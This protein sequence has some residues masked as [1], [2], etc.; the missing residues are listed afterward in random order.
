MHIL[1]ITIELAARQKQYNTRSL[2]IKN[3]ND[4]IHL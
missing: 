1:H 4:T 3:L 2:T